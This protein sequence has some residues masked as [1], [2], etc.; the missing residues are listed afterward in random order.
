MHLT[1]SLYAITFIFILAAFV[2]LA[3]LL[4]ECLE[5]HSDVG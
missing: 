1:M 2:C 3:F 5:I 4:A